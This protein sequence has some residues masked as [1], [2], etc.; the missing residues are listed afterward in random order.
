MSYKSLL[1]YLCFAAIATNAIADIPDLKTFKRT[2]PTLVFEENFN[3]DVSKW[4]KP[5]KNAAFSVQ[6]HVG[7][8][9]SPGL[10]AT[11]TDKRNLASWTMPIK[12]VPGKAYKVSFYYRFDNIRTKQKNGRHIHTIVCSIHNI[13]DKDTGK[14]IKEI[15]FWVPSGNTNGQLRYYTSTVVIPKNAKPD[16]TFSIHVDWWLNGTFIY[17]NFTISSL[18]IPAELQLAYPDRMT[19]DKDGKISVRYQCQGNKAPANA[20]MLITAND[21][22]K[23]AKYNNGLFTASFGKFAGEKVNVKAVLFDRKLRRIISEHS[24][25]LNNK[26]AEPISYID[27]HNR[28]IFNGKPF[29]PLGSCIMMRM[30]P[31]DYNRLKDAGF[32]AI[33]VQPM[34]GMKGHSRKNTSA[35]LLSYINN[36]NSYGLKTLMF[37]QLM[38]PEKEFI[39]RRLEKAFNNVESTEGIVREIGKTLKNNPNVIGYYLADE[40][41]AKELPNTQILRERINFADPTHV[42]TTLTNTVDFVDQYVSTGDVILYDAYPFNSHRRPGVKGDLVDTD[43]ALARFASLKTPFWFVPQGFDWARHPKRHMFGKTLEEKRKHRIPSEEEI[44]ALPLLSIMYGA[45]GFFFYSY[46]EIFVHGDNVQPGFSKIFWPR[47]VKA[48]K[49]L[50]ML[51]PFILSVEKAKEVKFTVKSGAIRYKTLTA[52]GKT[53]IIIVSLKDT[54]NKAIGILPKGKRFVSLNKKTKIVGDKFEF[55]SSNVNYDILI[56]Q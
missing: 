42:T 49:T 15:N 46:H 1:G 19:L 55:A 43:K 18:D 50:K 22:Q 56:S 53:A 44:V 12:V 54:P 21:K 2:E 7:E 9:G 40:N 25:Q 11:S 48:A 16:A 51:E 33:Q 34:G 4:I 41:V 14:K 20:E 3:S 47:V 10:I 13:K 28:L 5:K 32:N 52:N 31:E 29:M 35:N 36:A 37:M 23:L 17:D 8:T 6:P 24:W 38:I 45:K 39:R 27:K 26:P 30:K